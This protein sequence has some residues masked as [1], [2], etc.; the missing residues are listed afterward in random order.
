MVPEGDKVRA[1]RLSLFFKQGI[2]QGTP[3]LFFAH[4]AAGGQALHIR[5]AH[6]TGHTQDA[7]YFLRMCRISLGFGPQAMIDAQAPELQVQP[8]DK[9][10]KYG[11]QRCGIRTTGKGQH[12]T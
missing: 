11:G 5:F 10:G 7:A 2:S 4:A 1:T 9:Q 3:G 8:G 6:G 12:K